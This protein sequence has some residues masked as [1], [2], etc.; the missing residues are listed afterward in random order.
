MII[1]R[2]LIVPG[3]NGSGPGHWQTLWEEKYGCERVNQRDWR[4]PDLAEWVDTLNAFITANSERA[5]LIAHSLGCLAVAHWAYAHPENTGQ[6]KCALLVAPPDLES[7]SSIPQT[8]RRFAAHEIIPFPSVLVGSENDPYMTL[9]SV[10][11]LAAQWG[12]C[13]VNAGAVGHIN[14]DSGYGP[15]SQGE[16]LLHDLIKTRTIHNNAHHTDKND[17]AKSFCGSF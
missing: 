5:V 12:S 3:L 8:M 10:R 1:M 9:E 17:F 2:I 7:S 11:K 13:F 16:T 14:L 15:W 4:N 6:V